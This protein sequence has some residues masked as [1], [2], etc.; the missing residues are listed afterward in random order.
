MA[1]FGS[2]RFAANNTYAV[3]ERNRVNDHELVQIVLE[4]DVIPVPSYHV[5]G[6]VSLS[7]N[8]QLAVKFTEDL[9]VGFAVLVAGDRRLKVSR[10]R[11]AVCSC[12]ETTKTRE[13]GKLVEL[14]AAA[15]RRRRFRSVV[16]LSGPIRAVESG[17]RT[18]RER[19]LSTD[20]KPPR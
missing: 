12:E 5:E 4:G 18:L 1:R 11:Q 17:R 20:R 6:A 10:I 8:E 7:G 2:T 19:I 15:S 16:Y 13:S 14:A 3:I 9:V